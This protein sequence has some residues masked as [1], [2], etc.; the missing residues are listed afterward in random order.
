MAEIRPLLRSD[1][2]A[3]AKL[4]IANLPPWT[5]D[6]RVTSSLAATF[7]DDPWADE[8]LPS[9][10][11][12]QD[13]KVVGFIGAQVRRFR[14]G[15]RSLTGVCASDLTVDPASRGGATGALLFRRLLL[16]GQDFTYTD[17]ASDEAVRMCR[18]FGGDLDHAR[19]CDWMIT[20]RPARWLSRLAIATA[21]RQR[22]H[23]DVPVRALALKPPRRGGKP[24]TPAGIAG[25]DTDAAGIVAALAKIKDGPRLR[26]DYEEAQLGYLLREVEEHFGGLTARVV[27]REGEPIGW[28]AHV[29]VSP[30]VVRVLHL[31]AG[32]QDTPNVL[33]ELLVSARVSGAAAICGRV[34]P[35]LTRTLGARRT[36]VGFARRPW[37]HTREP[38]I[39]ALLGSSDAAV[40]QLDSEWFVN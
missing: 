40:T 23:W 5:E 32:E 37:I 18:V 14:L 15:D 19:C 33:G 9:L 17:T 39:R 29:P 35:H 10:V 6:E 24:E 2:P 8:S 25:V 21:R 20:L 4:L 16:A 26:V 12:A 38:E 30:V 27:H 31:F 7:V 28:Y 22:L 13:G 3:V 34:E 1:L 11:A 36:L